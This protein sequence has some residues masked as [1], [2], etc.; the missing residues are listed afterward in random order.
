MLHPLRL[1]L[2]FKIS[3]AMIV[4]VLHDVVEDS[5]VTF[6]D[7]A[8][9]GFSERV[10]AMLRLLTH[11]KDTPYMDYIRALGSDP[12]ARKVK[13][14]DLADNMDLTRIAE[15]T[16]KDLARL[17]RYAEAYRFLVGEETNR[18]IRSKEE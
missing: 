8:E 6:A 15:P 3:E 7:L 5:E 9:A 2:Q 10:V 16:E 1:M 14:A 4:A 12:L 18:L 17:K 11:A 13:L